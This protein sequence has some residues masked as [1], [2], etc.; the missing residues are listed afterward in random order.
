L[1]PATTH[2]L[3]NKRPIGVT[4]TQRNADAVAGDIAIAEVGRRRGVKHKH[5]KVTLKPHIVDPQQ[6]LD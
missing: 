1:S 3:G 5:A 2:P 4:I 6:R